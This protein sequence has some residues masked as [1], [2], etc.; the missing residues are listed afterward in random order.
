ME[1]GITDLRTYMKFRKDENLP[2]KD[3]EIYSL[4][5]NIYAQMKRLKEINIYHRDIKPNNIIITSEWE[6][7]LIDHGLALSFDDIGDIRE[8]APEG[9]P[10]FMPKELEDIFDK[11]K[12]KFLAPKVTYD[13]WKGDL[14]SLKKTIERILQDFDQQMSPEIQSLFNK[15]EEVDPKEYDWKIP[16]IDWKFYEKLFPQMGI[17]TGIKKQLLRYR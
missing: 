17:K 1:Y 3:E 5:M 14:Y 15:L 10:G 2:W 16:S 8:V 6:F 13:L 7:K 11:A 12:Q 4:I 9:T